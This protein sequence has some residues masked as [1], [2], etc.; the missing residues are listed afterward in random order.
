M[1]AGTMPLA[2]AIASSVAAAA[3][4]AATVVPVSRR[5]PR[6]SGGVDASDGNSLQAIDGYGTNFC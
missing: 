1:P 4:G 2:R 6:A 5:G 3:G